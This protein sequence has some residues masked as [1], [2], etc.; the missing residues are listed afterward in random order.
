MRLFCTASLRTVLEAFLLR[1]AGWYW[2]SRIHI[3]LEAWQ[4]IEQVIRWPEAP[5]MLRTD[6]HC[7]TDDA[8]RLLVRD[9]FS[10]EHSYLERVD[11]RI[12]PLN[13]RELVRTV[14]P[15]GS[16]G[17]DLPD[18][19]RSNQDSLAESL[20][21]RIGQVAAWPRE[22]SILKEFPQMEFI[23]QRQ[24]MEQVASAFQSERMDGSGREPELVVL[25]EVC[26]P[27]S[28]ARTIRKLVEVQERAS[29]AGLYWRELRPVSDFG[30]PFDLSCRV[31]GLQRNRRGDRCVGEARCILRLALVRARSAAPVPPGC[32][33]SH[34]RLQPENWTP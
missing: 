33:W 25:P 1:I 8:L 24:I 7:D 30:T 26:I 3:P 23:A 16:T 5:A 21:V 32:S 15:Q 31:I 17:P 11:I 2:R 12:D 29:L 20:V 19:L 13:D 4:C 22:D 9:T 10:I 14:S 34:G 28:E 18:E 27:E 6:V